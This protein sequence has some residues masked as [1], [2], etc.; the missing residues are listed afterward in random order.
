MDRESIIDVNQ[1]GSCANPCDRRTSLDTHL[2]HLTD[3]NHESWTSGPSGITVTTGPSVNRNASAT[4]KRKTC[5]NVLNRLAAGQSARTDVVETRVEEFPLPFERGVVREQEI[6]VEDIAEVGP[7][8]R[9]SV[10][11]RSAPG[12]PGRG[13]PA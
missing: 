6:P 2:V 8:A 1:L 13:Q 3:I 7:I 9:R 11:K 5:A 10:P 12:E 4:R